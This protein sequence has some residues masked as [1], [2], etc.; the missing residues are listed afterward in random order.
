M[1][2]VRCGLRE[3]TYVSPEDVCENCWIE[4]WV[5]GMGLEGREKAAY[6][7]ELKADLRK[8]KKRKARAESNHR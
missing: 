4:W 1:F 7:R 8:Q 5:D 2:C 6:R 3:A